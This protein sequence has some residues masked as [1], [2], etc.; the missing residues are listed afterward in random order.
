MF[1]KV[2]SSKSKIIFKTTLLD[3][4]KNVEYFYCKNCGFLQTEDPFWLKESYSS[5]ISSLDTG[6]MSRNI[7][8]MQVAS[9][10]IY[11]LFDRQ[12]K[13][14]DFGGGHG[15]FT[16]F[17]RDIG[18]DYLWSDLHADNLFANGFEYEAFSNKI[19]LVSAFECFEHFVNPQEEI[20]RI[21]KISPNILFTTQLLPNP[22][23]SPNN[24]WYYALESG[25][26]ISFYSYK[27]LE[28]IAQKHDLNFFSHWGIHLFSSKKIKVWFFRKLI[29]WQYFLSRYV[30]KKMKSKTV[31]DMNFIKKNFSK[32]RE[33]C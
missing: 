15:I 26:H 2:C 11:F 19:E 29:E 22:V 17:M 30:K 28:F 21:I 4:Y 12:G 32:E 14:L 3:K 23:P 24:W 7:S 33:V 20:D 25:Q 16:R 10:I 8:L 31:V 1:C 18:F 5:A 9:V 13:Y 6:I 27:T